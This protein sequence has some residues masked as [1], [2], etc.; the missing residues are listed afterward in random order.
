MRIAVV[1]LALFASPLAAHV[2]LDEPARRYDDMKDGPCGRGGANDGRTSRFKRYAAG[3]TITMRWTETIDHEG[4]WVV[5]FDNDGADEDDFASTILYE[6]PDPRGTGGEQV[7]AEV[8]LPDVEC[9]NCTLRLLQVM[10]TSD[11]VRPQDL[12]FQCADIVLGEGESSP[13][14]T[15]QAGGAPGAMAVLALALRR[16]RLRRG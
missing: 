12:Y 16:R 7:T 10:T 6:A 9:T 4:S 11:V 3:E 2:L 5:G 13:G 14:V 8:T 15:C 1:M